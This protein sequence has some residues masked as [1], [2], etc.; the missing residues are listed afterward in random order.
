MDSW[1]SFSIRCRALKPYAL[2][3]GLLVGSG[4]RQPVNKSIVL[5]GATTLTL[6]EGEGASAAGGGGMV[7][8]GHGRFAGA[9]P[10]PSLWHATA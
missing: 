4:F 8:A 5:R 6:M 3:M 1:Q 10:E 2:L 9:A 7:R